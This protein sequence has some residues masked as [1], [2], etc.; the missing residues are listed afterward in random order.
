MQLAPTALLPMQLR[1]CERRR[2]FASVMQARWS[3]EQL[4][5]DSLFSHHYSSE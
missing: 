5:V 3:C 2:S 4:A 1:V